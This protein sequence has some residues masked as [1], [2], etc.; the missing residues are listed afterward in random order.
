MKTDYD[1]LG[2]PDTVTPEQLKE[3]WRALALEH[4][5]DRGGDADAF[6]RLLE[7]YRRLIAVVSEPRPCLECKGS[8]RRRVVRGFSSILLDCEACGGIG[9]LQ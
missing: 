9:L 6:Q 7:A 4:H 2:V 3:R 8:G 5:P 1:L